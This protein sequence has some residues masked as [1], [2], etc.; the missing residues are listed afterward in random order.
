M[1]GYQLWL[2]SLIAYFVG[3]SFLWAGYPAVAAGICAAGLML[4][5]ES[6]SRR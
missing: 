4:G 2:L 5:F 1:T 6:N 3:S